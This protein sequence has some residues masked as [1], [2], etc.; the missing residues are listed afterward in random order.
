MSVQIPRP[1]DIIAFA[2]TLLASGLAVSVR[3]HSAVAGDCLNAPNSPAPAN[4]HWYYR[5][6]RAQQRHCWYIR[7]PD[8]PSQQGSVPT[9]PEAPIAKPSRSVSA[10]SPYSLASFKDFMAH[11]GGAELSDQQVEALYADFLAW[12]RRAKN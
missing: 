9:P 7:A 4:S 12:N 6:D 8:P 2:F 5:T 10:A 1:I 11:R 3:D